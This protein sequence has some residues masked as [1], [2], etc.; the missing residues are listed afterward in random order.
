MCC[1]YCRHWS[2]VCFM[3]HLVRS[4]TNTFLLVQQL[5]AQL[6]VDQRSTFSSWDSLS[7]S[8]RAD[9]EARHLITC[10]PGMPPPARVPHRVH[11]GYT[12]DA[13]TKKNQRTVHNDL[14]TVSHVLTCI[15]NLS[16]VH[17]C[18][19]VWPACA[20]QFCMTWAWQCTAAVAKHV[21][22]SNQL[23]F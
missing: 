2:A 3:L 5:N 10:S 22:F 7:A 21:V 12:S 4:C 1:A 11:H 16:C 23:I 20:L 18:S 6:P 15:A 17:S 14:Y 13:R 19:S 8:I 9:P